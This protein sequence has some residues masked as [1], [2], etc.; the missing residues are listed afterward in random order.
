MIMTT[1]ASPSPQTVAQLIHMD[2]QALRQDMTTILTMARN[3][4]L[5]MPG[6]RMSVLDAMVGLLQ[7]IVTRMEQVDQSLEA[8]HQKLDHP[9]I[10]NILRRM[11]DSD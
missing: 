7:T 10:A 3:T 2:T 6:E 1:T 8:L 4:A 9:G 11:I 5:P